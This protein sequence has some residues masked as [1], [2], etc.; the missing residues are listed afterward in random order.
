[1]GRAPRARQKARAYVE[2]LVDQHDVRDGGRLPTILT[3]AAR[4][5]V[6]PATMAHALHALRDE[7]ALTV[8]QG[9]GIRIR[10]PVDDPAPDQARVPSVPSGG[11]GRVCRELQSRVSDGVY[12]PGQV[13]PSLQELSADLGTSY[14]T[15]KKALDYLV[16]AGVAAHHKRSYRLVEHHIQTSGRS[17]VELVGNWGWP[18]RDSERVQAIL[19]SLE[20][21]CA[22][23]GLSVRSP[24]GEQRIAPHA[25]ALG[26]IVR[27]S[28]L[29]QPNAALGLNELAAQGQAVAVLDDQGLA[30]R[31]SA[32]ARRARAFALAWP[33]TCGRVV[34]RYLYELGHRQVAFISPIHK[35]TWAQNRYHGLCTAFSDAGVHS[36]VRLF[37]RDD[38]SVR[39]DDAF[40]A[41][42]RREVEDMVHGLVRGAQT[43]EQQMIARAVSR[44]AGSIGVAAGREYL[45]QAAEALFDEASESGCT[46][47]VGHNDPVALAAVEYLERHTVAVPGDVSVVGF[48]NSLEAGLT[49]LTSYDFNIGA[50]VRA[51]IDHIVGAP[52]PGGHREVFEAAGYV[53]ERQTTRSV[54]GV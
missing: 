7:G 53:V 17:T 11:W 10:T 2:S 31:R 42:I 36:A 46:A 26:S 32:G 54:P 51:M 37:A 23:R 33:E 6:A 22:R 52:A 43:E 16:R 4:C 49:G 18:Q 19:S 44:R 34:G 20:A 8:S 48:D 27:A 1:M 25:T 3:L 29:Y 40:F 13:L 45:H 35:N 14:R 28:A 47:W 39:T 38:L 5:G 41:A 21:E 15:L 12:Q 50:L 24:M 30:R 9:S